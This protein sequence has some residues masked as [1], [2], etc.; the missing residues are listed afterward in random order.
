MSEMLAH[1]LIQTAITFIKVIL[2]TD[3]LVPRA[4]SIFLRV[5]RCFGELVASF[6][7][8]VSSGAFMRN[9]GQR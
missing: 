7:L 8:S 9:A 2:I 3:L 6:R 5:F 4:C 1:V